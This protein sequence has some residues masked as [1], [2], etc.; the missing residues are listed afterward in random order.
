M[1]RKAICGLR[2]MPGFLT[3]RGLGCFETEITRAVSEVLGPAL[4]V[5]FHA[6]RSVSSERGI[7]DR[8]MN[9]GPLSSLFDQVP[10]LR[11]LAEGRARLVR[12][13]LVCLVQAGRTFGERVDHIG[14]PAG[15]SHSAGR[16]VRLV[17][18]ETGETAIFK[19]RSV[20][21]ERRWAAFVRGLQLVNPTCGLAA[22]AVIASATEHGWIQYVP[23]EPLA[24]LAD[25]SLFYERAGALLFWAWL[26]NTTDLLG[27]NIVAS[28]SQPFLVDAETVMGCR[29]CANHRDT[30]MLP[31]AQTTMTGESCFYGALAIKPTRRYQVPQFENIG[32][33]EMRLGYC[34]FEERQPATPTLDGVGV[35]VGKY[36]SQVLDGYR[37]AFQLALKFRDCVG[38]LMSE[39]FHSQEGCRMTFRPTVIYGALRTRYLHTISCLASEAYDLREI[40]SDLPRLHDL[41]E[42]QVSELIDHEAH[43]IERLDVPRFWICQERMMPLDWP[44]NTAVPL[45][46]AIDRLRGLC[47]SDLARHEDSICTSL[48]I[49]KSAA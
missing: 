31:I 44:Q 32:K 15:D 26:T 48:R 30:G 36:I 6:L 9:V 5:R 23:H 4:Y 47:P 35:P 29:G 17:R 45:L 11:A 14:P 25:A 38:D 40:L 33:D 46:R 27:T 12:D 8:F 39:G 7:Y 18:F 2:E 42:A 21:P 34:W 3:S 24:S 16:S 49:E 20:E 41:E 37:G 1:A 43:Q 28:G 22:P 10:R 19:P 13:H